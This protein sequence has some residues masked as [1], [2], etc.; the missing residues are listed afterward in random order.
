MNV[1]AKMLD[2][3]TYAYVKSDLR[4]VSKNLSVKT[5][6]GKLFAVVAWG[7][8]LIKNNTEL[9]REWAHID[10]ARGAALDRHG[11]NYGVK[12]GGAD[13]FFYRLLIKV[14]IISQLSGGDIDT[15]LSAIATLYGVEGEKVGLAEVFPAKLKISLNK[16]DIPEDYFDVEHLINLLIKRIIAAGI[17]YD[18]WLEIVEKLYGNIYV[19]AAVTATFHRKNTRA[20]DGTLDGE[21]SNGIHYIGSVIATSFF[22]RE[23]HN[24]GHSLNN[25]KT[26]GNIFFGGA[27][28]CSYFYADV[29]E[30]VL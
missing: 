16:N 10:H 20:Y 2:L 6:I 3:I 13:D 21:K 15:V 30:G 1:L 26:G 17:G 24:Q 8:E 11:E 23:A 14:K 12:R 4:N 9:V 27:S 25:T 19:G 7:F 22:H 18:V 29:K 28:L 5:N